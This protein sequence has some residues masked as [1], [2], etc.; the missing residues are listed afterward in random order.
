MLLNFTK[1]ISSE[2]LVIYG[3]IIFIILLIVSI[4]VLD[5]KEKKKRIMT[6]TQELR[7]MDLRKTEED[8]AKAFKKQPLAHETELRSVVVEKKP[9]IE[10]AIPA[11]K[12]D[13]STVQEVITKQEEIEEKEIPTEGIID[14]IELPKEQ[15]LLTIDENL[16]VEDDLEKTSAQLQ[17]ELLAQELEKAKDR[18]EEKI[19]RF[20]AEQE[21]NAIISYNELLKVCDDLYDKNEKVQYMDEGNEPINLQELRSRFKQVSTMNQEI[22]LL[23]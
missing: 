4:V 22:E 18:E 1:D 5:K 23:D 13:I 10:E 17:L 8:Y 14:V 9:V 19:R 2:I 20:E 21:E 11:I 7:L 6:K 12:E 15:E 3:L 16:Y